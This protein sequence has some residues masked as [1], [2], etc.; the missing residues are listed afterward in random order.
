MNP[1][2]P[3]SAPAMASPTRPDNHVLVVFGA[4][5]DLA[6]RKL[7]PGLFRLAASGLL[8]K[9]YRIVG[10]APRQFSLSDS[11]FKKHAKDAVEEFGGFTPTPEAWQNFEAA[12]F[13]RLRRSDDTAPLLAAVDLAEKEI[14]GKPR[15]PFT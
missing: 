5:G 11:D 10:S 1:R 2:T 8:P 6:K 7:L 9:Q 4:T 3:K 15:R 14:G 12:L 13:L